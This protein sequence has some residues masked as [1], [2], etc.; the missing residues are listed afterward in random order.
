MKYDFTTIRDGREASSAK[1]IQMDNAVPNLPKEIVPLSVADM[2]FPLA[3]EIAEA[4]NR[5]LADAIVGYTVTPDSYY[6]A[7]IRWMDRRHNWKLK[8]EDILPYQGVVPMIA[9]AVE[10]FTEE[11]DGVL[12]LPPVYH[13]FRMVIE[14]ANRT[15]IT[16][17]L[18]E[19]ER[20]YTIDFDDLAEKSKGVKLL[21]FC[22]PHNPTGR[23]W[24]KGELERVAQ[25]ARENDLVVFVDE[26]HHDWIHE[27]HEHTVFATIADGVRVLTGTAPTK[28]FN[29]AGAKVSSLIIQDPE[30]REQFPVSSES[31]PSILGL[32]MGEF[33]Y[34]YAEEWL[35][36]AIAQVKKN[37]TAFIEIMKQR[38]PIVRIAPLEGTYL[39]WADLRAMA[40][41]PEERQRFLQ[42]AAIFPIYGEIFGEEGMGFVRINLAAPQGVIEA[43]AHRLA[44]AI[45]RRA[46]CW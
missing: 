35:N 32:K 36:A 45:E 43:A 28:T 37:E 33:A 38:A 11:G 2:E 9:Q 42:E 25:I 5:Y 18:I 7:V 46:C 13:P 12:I 14:K 16:S 21:V 29:L 41:D 4:M 22:S 26:I 6:E 27:G 10:T 34:N 3:P 20:E 24:T 39:L 31:T 19:N 1:W 44:D 17:P 40:Q 8:K 30:L 15:T 23:V